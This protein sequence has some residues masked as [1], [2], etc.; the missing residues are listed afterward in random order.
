MRLNKLTSYCLKT[1]NIFAIKRSKSCFL[2][3]TSITVLAILVSRGNLWSH[4]WDL[5]VV[6][7]RLQFFVGNAEV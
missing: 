1:Q 2:L 5:G 4:G 7:R 6:E 3:E